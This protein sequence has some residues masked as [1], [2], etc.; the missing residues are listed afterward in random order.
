MAQSRANLDWEKQFQL[1]ID[2]EQ[3]RAKFSCR[4]RMTDACSMCGD[5]C[6]IKIAKEALKR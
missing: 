1:S 6:A 4:S 3:A 5:L 2:P